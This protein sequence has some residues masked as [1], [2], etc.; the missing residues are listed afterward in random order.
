MFLVQEAEIIRSVTS[1]VEPI[2]SKY[3][4]LVCLHTKKCGWDLCHEEHNDQDQ[5]PV[6]PLLPNVVLAISK[7]Q[8]KIF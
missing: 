3:A 7:C 2:M 6:G 5:S 1:S 4:N 8:T